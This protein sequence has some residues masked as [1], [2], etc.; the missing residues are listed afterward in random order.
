MPLSSLSQAAF[1][2]TSELD[3]K[4]LCLLHVSATITESEFSGLGTALESLLYCLLVLK[5]VVYTL[6]ALTYSSATDGQYCVFLAQVTFSGSIMC[7]NSV[8]S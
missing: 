2:S 6:N 5:Q 4:T 7:L 1:I 3:V 8:A